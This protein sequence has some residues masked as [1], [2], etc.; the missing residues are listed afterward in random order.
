MQIYWTPPNPLGD[1]TGYRIYY[2]GGSSGNVSISGGSIDN[3]TV[4]GLQNGAR[5]TISIVGISD[6]LPSGRINRNNIPLSEIF[7]P[8]CANTCDRLLTTFCALNTN[9]S[10][11]ANCNGELNN[12]HH[13]L[14][15]LECSQWLSGGQL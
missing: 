7:Q 5:Y 13:H 9:S 2:S 3:H 14:P 11:H 15:L 10:R 1:T 6:H 8:A 4:T 12:S